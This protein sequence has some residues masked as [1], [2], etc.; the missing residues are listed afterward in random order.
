[1]YFKVEGENTD[2][3]LLNSDTY[4]LNLIYLTK[5]SQMRPQISLRSETKLGFKNCNLEH[6]SFYGTP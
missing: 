4:I 2:T 3:I 6:L 1:M 5:Y